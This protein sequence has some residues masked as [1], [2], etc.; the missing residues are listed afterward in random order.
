M[1]LAL[2]AAVP[3]SAGQAGPVTIRF[4][5]ATTTR[6]QYGGRTSGSFT[7]SGRFADG[8][9]VRT[10]PGLLLPHMRGAFYGLLA[11]GSVAKRPGT[12]GVA[13]SPRSAT[14]QY[15]RVAIH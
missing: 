1:L 8:G 3:A 12:L 15:A 5:A 13:C 10:S 7:M 6:D 14:H 4:Q 9:T 2:I 11:R